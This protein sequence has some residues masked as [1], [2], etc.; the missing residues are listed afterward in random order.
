MVMT[1]QYVAGELSLLLAEVQGLATEH[2]CADAAR[3]LR[4][5]AE[6]MPRAA[7]GAVALG[8][9]RLVDVL[10]WCSLAAGDVAAFERQAEVG[11][12]LFE[13]GVCAGLLDEVSS[14][15]IGVWQ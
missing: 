8:G 9:V 3:L 12:R 15:R 7:L 14:S 5:D 2:V 13:F 10:C 11:A 4:W 6:T 1:Q